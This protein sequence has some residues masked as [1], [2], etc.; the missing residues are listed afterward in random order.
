MYALY[1]HTY[2]MQHIYTDIQRKRIV[3]IYVYIHLLNVYIHMYTYNIYTIQNIYTYIHT[4]Y[5]YIYVF[6]MYIYTYKVHIQRK[7]IDRKAEIV[8]YFLKEISSSAA[9]I[10]A[11]KRFHARIRKCQAHILKKKKVRDLVYSSFIT[12]PV[13]ASARHIF[14]KK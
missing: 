9:V 1:V 7:R 4:K 2:C 10:V 6:C 11:L 5:I 13:F 8:K 3:R 12:T 14:S